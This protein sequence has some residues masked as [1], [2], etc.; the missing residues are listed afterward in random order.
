[1]PTHSGARPS[2]PDFDEVADELYGLPP[3]EFTATRIRYEKQAKQA[4]DADLA[5]RLRALGKPT[6]TAWLANQ[7]TREHR[8]ELQ[9]LFELGAGLREA[10][11]TLAGDQ[12]RQLSRQQHELV[13]ALVQQ[14]RQLARAAGRAASEDTVRGLEDTLHA[15]LADEQAAD[16]LLAGRLTQTLHRDGFTQASEASSPAPARLPRASEASGTAS[17]RH[18]EQRQRA[19]SDVADAER[20]VAKADAAREE[21]QAQLMQAEATVAEA[22]DQVE[23]LRRQLDAALSTQSDAERDRRSQTTAAQ[24]AERALSDAQQRLAD[25]QNRR[26]RLKSDD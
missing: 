7:L 2:A 26:D 14:A 3:E 12:L 8:D 11:R 10:T 15:A 13:Y 1:M 16:L 23:E 21:A 24:R 18:D 4:G 9:P 20:A 25:A 5:G 6:V 22:S 17:K 19:E